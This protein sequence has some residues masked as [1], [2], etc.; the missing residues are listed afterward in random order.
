MATIGFES[1]V[2]SFW[3]GRDRD[4]SQFPARSRRLPHEP[5]WPERDSD[6]FHTALVTL[7][8]AD[9]GLAGADMAKLT[10]AEAAKEGGILVEEKLMMHR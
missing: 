7:I 10:F 9:D 4:G 6:A 3:A 1:P 2:G 5:D 8:A